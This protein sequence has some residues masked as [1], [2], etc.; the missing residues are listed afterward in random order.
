MYVIQIRDADCIT[1]IDVARTVK[2]ARVVARKLRAALGR[3]AIV[4][5]DTTH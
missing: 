2:A 4:Q 1:I 3:D 5:I